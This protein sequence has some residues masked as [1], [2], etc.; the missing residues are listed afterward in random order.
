MKKSVVIVGGGPAG[1]AAAMNLQRHGIPSVIVER[2]K[3]PRFH[4]G[5]AMT[6]QCGASVRALGLEEEMLRRRFPV[7]TGAA[8]VGARGYKWGLPIAARDKDWNLVPGSTWQVRRDEFDKMLLDTAVERGT[9]LIEGEAVRPILGDDGAVRGVTIRDPG[10][11]TF[12]IES[13]MV[14]DCSGLA[15]FLANAGV[16]GPKYSG[17]YDKQIAI[18]SQVA[19]TVRYESGPNDTL[20]FFQKKYHWAWFIPLSDEVVSVGV[21]CPAAYFKEKRE[22]KADFLKRELRELNPE[23]SRLVPNNNLVDG[24][25]AITNYSYQVR[26][27]TGKGFICVADAHRFIDPI[28]SYGLC[29]AFEEAK[30]AALA[31]KDYLEGIGRDDPD[32]FAEYRLIAEQAIDLAEDMT[33]AFWEHPL[34]FATLV[35]GQPGEMIDLF[36]GRLW[37]RQPNIPAQRFRRWLSRDRTYDPED[38]FSVPI[39]SRYHPERA[40][41]W[42]NEAPRPGIEVQGDIPAESA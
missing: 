41:I 32:P 14:L 22:S 12:D 21:V 40:N 2:M 33:D 39:G 13:E 23:L 10:G 34:P 42:A 31:T 16:T 37:E 25:R 35:R 28:F 26:R 36:A 8:V 38:D 27:F 9:E 1:S 11:K 5:E 20:I 6:G 7:K 4:T 17:N 3:F 29:F 24:V 15:T 30:R 18:F 19:D